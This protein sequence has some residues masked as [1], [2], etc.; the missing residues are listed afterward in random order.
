LRV[1]DDPSRIFLAS[2][3]LY[4]EVVPKAAFN[5]RIRAAVFYERFFRQTEWVKDLDK[6]VS[7]AEEEEEEATRFG[8]GAMDALHLAA[9]HLASASEFVNGEANLSRISVPARQDCLPSTGHRGVHGA[10][11]RDTLCQLRYYRA[12]H[13]RVTIP[14][15]LAAQAESRGVPVDAYV[16]ELL[17]QAAASDSPVPPRGRGREEIEAFFVAMA[18]SS[19]SLPLLPTESFTRG[20]FY[21]PPK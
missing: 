17:E 5:K 10:I 12:M 9:A 20:S 4:L 11:R 18:E 2:S 6:I 16:R 15:Q 14:D 8:L 1:F 7:L 21:G 3:F 19:E 13:I